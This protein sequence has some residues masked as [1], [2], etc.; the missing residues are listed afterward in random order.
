MERD[1]RLIFFETIIYQ[2]GS[3]KLFGN[4]SFAAGMQALV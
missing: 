4:I 3:K 1:Q 2:S